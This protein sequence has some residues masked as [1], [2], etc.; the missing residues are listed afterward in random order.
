ML[1]LVAA[2]FL[3]ALSLA[4]L[5]LV[6]TT[7]PAARANPDYW[8]V[9]PQAPNN[10]CDFPTIQEAIDAASSGDVIRVVGPNV[11]TEN[12]VIT[13]SIT[14]RGGC[15][16]ATCGVRVPQVFVT[17]INGNG[18][19]R[20]ITIRGEGTV[21]KP[22]VDGFVITG[23]DASTETDP[24]G[25]G[26]GSWNAAPFIFS[27]VI[28]GNVAGKVVSSDAYGGGIALWDPGPYT[29]VGLN[30]VSDNIANADAGSFR[31]GYGGGIAVYGGTATL[32]GNE[33][34]GNLATAS[35]SHSGYG[36]GIYVFSGTFSLVYNEVFTNR[37]SAGYD[38]YGGGIYL[39][40]VEALVSS[41]EVY[42]NLAASSRYG[43]GGGLA[44]EGGG[45]LTI[46]Q[47]LIYTNTGSITSNGYGGGMYLRRCQATVSENNII[48]NLSS[49]DYIGSGGGVWAAESDVALSHNMILS[50]T[51]SVNGEGDGG[52]AH[53][54]NSTVTMDSD[55][56]WANSATLSPTVSMSPLGN[57]VYVG[58]QD[59]SP[60]LTAT[61]LVIFQ[62]V[63]PAGGYGVYAL[64][65]APVSLTLSI[66]NSTIVSNTDT[67][68]TCAG[69]VAE[70]LVNL[71]LWGNG[72]DLNGCSAVY[73]DIEDGDAGTGNLSADPLFVD[74]AE[75]DLHLRQG[76]PCIDG[77]AGPVTCPIVPDHDWDGES[78]PGG[79][80][81]DIGADEF[82][83]YTYLPLVLRG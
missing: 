25:G 55:V 5:S 64:G 22:V 32:W 56:L 29:W 27:N 40:E 13:K 26:I 38:G 34:S 80:G 36:G 48:D 54:Y 7:V 16:S 37:A 39:D 83:M 57:A 11:Y 67:G 60:V 82:W 24:V 12:L 21:I 43:R 41:N 23:G 2:A 76:S 10:G 30:Q 74:A 17:T 79:S 75:G 81:Y 49:R 71:I 52:G 42:D 35:S 15:S 69:P 28:T 58:G 20:V 59:G 70:T 14:L 18:N 63:A 31:Y 44:A 46:T 62:N 77:G 68:L 50:N 33:V 9:C 45:P 73:S 4:V 8:A 61:N 3:A 6:L 47:N 72:D 19:G 66:A 1:S 78:R 51:S 65:I 53:L